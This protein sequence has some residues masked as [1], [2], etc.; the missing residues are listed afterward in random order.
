M[1]RYQTRPLKRLPNLS[2][3]NFQMSILRVTMREPLTRL[4]TT[5]RSL[6]PQIPTLS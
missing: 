1:T 4:I 6:R 3:S 2:L 5:E